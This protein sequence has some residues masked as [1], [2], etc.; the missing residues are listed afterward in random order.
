MWILSSWS[1]LLHNVTATRASEAH[2]VVTAITSFLVY[3]V[4]Y[5]SSSWTEV[6][7]GLAGEGSWCPCIDSNNVD[8][9]GRLTNL[10]RKHPSQEKEKF[11]VPIS[12]GIVQVKPWGPAHFLTAEVHG[13][14][15]TDTIVFTAALLLIFVLTD[16]SCGHIGYEDLV[17]GFCGNASGRSLDVYLQRGVADF[18][19]M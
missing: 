6:M 1:R 16:K 10:P 19:R 11:I 7:E 18:A 14:P 4:T 12:T 17:S 5:K 3:V 9:K 15:E 2:F 13:T 8:I